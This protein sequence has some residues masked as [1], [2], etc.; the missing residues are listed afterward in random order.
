MAGDNQIRLDRAGRLLTEHAMVWIRYLQA[1]V[2]HVWPLISTKEGLNKWWVAPP[3]VFELKVGGLFRHHWDNTITSFQ[4]PQYID[5]AEP[6]G[7]YRATGGMRFELL[8]S[9]NHETTFVFIDTFGPDVLAS[10]AVEGK[11]TAFD[12]QPA[13][14]GTVWPSVAAGW[15]GAVDQLE[16]QFSD[17]V[18]SHTDE[19]LCKFYLDYLEN[20]Y[21]WLDM[22]QRVPE[23]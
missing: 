8:A 13:G 3:R 20:Q 14:P 21:R 23:N 12:R 22:V 15:H 18:P 10:E 1:P 5:I 9:G 7:S 17:E 19:E 11:P 6:T 4:A 2:D 16:R